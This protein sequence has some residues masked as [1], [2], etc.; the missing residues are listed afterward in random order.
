VNASVPVRA[1]SPPIV[2]R[3]SRSKREGSRTARDT[4]P[5]TVCEAAGLHRAR[6]PGCDS[7][8]VKLFRSSFSPGVTQS[9]SSTS[10]ISSWTNTLASES[11][12]SAGSK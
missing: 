8:P 5:H 11:V 4:A 9:V 1:S 2:T 6:R 3:R 7:M 10:V 12:R